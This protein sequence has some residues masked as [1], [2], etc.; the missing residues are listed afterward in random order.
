MLARAGVMPQ[1]AQR[2]M[3]HA[4]IKTTLRH[5]TDL[6]LSDQARAVAK[7]PRISEI[8]VA[9]T[10]T[11]TDG[12]VLIVSKHPQQYS[13]HSVRQTGQN[14]A[15]E[16]ELM[17]DDPQHHLD[18]KTSVSSGKHGSLRGRAKGCNKAGE[19]DRTPDIQLGKR[20]T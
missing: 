11:G 17:R 5:Y 7:L 1:E 2:Q 16:Y 20:T 8:Q 10:P 3:R 12:P 6:R 19:E 9:L 14:G 4:D 13:Q 15:P 18:R